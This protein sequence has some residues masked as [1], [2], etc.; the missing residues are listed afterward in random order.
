[1][2][3]LYRRVFALANFEVYSFAQLCGYYLIPSLGSN[4]RREFGLSL[5]PIAAN[6]VRPVELLCSESVLRADITRTSRIRFSIA[7]LSIPCYFIDGRYY[8]QNVRRTAVLSCDSKVH[9]TSSFLISPHLNFRAA[10]RVV[11]WLYLINRAYCSIFY[12]A[13]TSRYALMSPLRVCGVWVARS[14]AALWSSRQPQ[15]R[16]MNIIAQILQLFIVVLCPRPKLCTGVS[17][18]SLCICGL[19]VSTAHSQCFVF[20]LLPLV[21][22]STFHSTPYF[23]LG[24]CQTYTLSQWHG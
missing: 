18:T 16:T 8:P 10:N 24:R 4:Y 20:I 11:C 1:M 14:H 9:P 5:R 3:F 23:W 12:I 2:Q 17:T 19:L 22:C 13:T 21:I 15:P 6:R 7:V